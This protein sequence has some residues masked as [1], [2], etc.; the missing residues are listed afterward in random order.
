MPGGRAHGRRTAAAIL[1][2]GSDNAHGHPYHYVSGPHYETCGSVGSHGG[3]PKHRICTSGIHKGNVQHGKAIC[4]P[5]L[6][7]A[8]RSYADSVSTCAS[9]ELLPAQPCATF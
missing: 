5:C 9:A 1:V 3:G 4:H 6:S 8:A 2:T 7:K